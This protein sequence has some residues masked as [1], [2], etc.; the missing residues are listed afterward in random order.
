[1]SN[2]TGAFGQFLAGIIIIAGIFVMVRPNSQGPTLVNN[3]GS[4]LTNLL[5]A[6][7]G[8]GTWGS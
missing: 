6:A 1:M 8:G 7:T 3:V 2:L 5:N 4:G